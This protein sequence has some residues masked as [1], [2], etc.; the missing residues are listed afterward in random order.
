MTHLE[1]ISVILILVAGMAFSL[2]WKKLT[3]AAAITGAAIGWLIYAGAGYTGLTMLTVFFI[4]GT[5]ATSWKRNEKRI[6]PGSTYPSPGS[7]YQPT[8]HAGQVIANAG[9]AAIAGLLMIC[10]PPWRPL[11]KVMMAASLASAAADT[12][13]SELGMVYGRRFYNILTGRRDQKGL[14]GVI[15]IEGLL[16]GLAGSA[17][18]ALLYIAGNHFQDAAGNHIGYSR[19]FIILLAG[20]I[21]NLA[22]S[23]LGATLERRHLISNDIVNFGNTLVA[24]LAAGALAAWL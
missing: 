8:R 7:G 16:F 9:I 21:G 12:L 6:P 23:L 11:L 5:A 24:A 17:I 2:R 1:D 14:D 18:I 3:V 10:F 4:L 15:S 22:D 13:S 20:T 19:F